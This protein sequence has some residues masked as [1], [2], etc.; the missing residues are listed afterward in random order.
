MSAILIRGLDDRTKARLRI[1]AAEHGRSME[2]E[3]R[4]ILTIGLASNKKPQEN[5][6]ERIRSHIEP[7]KGFD[8]PIT[9]REPVRRP[10]AF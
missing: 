10:P 6:Y 5:I 3:A 4:E 8:L 1:Q 7:L 9:P 2:Q